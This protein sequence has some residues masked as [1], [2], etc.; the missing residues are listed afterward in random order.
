MIDHFFNLLEGHALGGFGHFVVRHIRIHHGHGASALV[1][2]KFLDLLRRI[3]GPPQG[4][5][6]AVTQ[7]V[8]CIGT[9]QKAAAGFPM[10]K[11]CLPDLTSDRF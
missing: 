6:D 4:A 2:E 5:S 9:A 8:V 10:G 3:A 1:T 7:C 11:A